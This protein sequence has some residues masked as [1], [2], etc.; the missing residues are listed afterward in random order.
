MNHSSFLFRSAV[1]TVLF[2]GAGFA[3]AGDADPVNKDGGFA[4]KGYDAV[5]YFQHGQPVKG[6][7]QFSHE[8]MGARWLFSS[9]GNR[10]QFAADP[11]RYAPQYG[12]YCS[13]AVS[14]GHTAKIDPEAWKIVDGKL[15]LNYSKGVQKMWEKDVPGYIQKANKNW[16][17]L[18]R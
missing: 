9:A 10:D 14:Q 13:Y 18:H 6:Q 7:T 15:Y 2:V 1:A 17:G 5:A 12:G 8:Y 16:P 11:G 3:F 4:I